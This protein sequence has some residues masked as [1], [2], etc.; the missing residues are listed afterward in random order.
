MCLSLLLLVSDVG[1]QFAFLYFFS[2]LLHDVCYGELCQQV[3]V[4]PPPLTPIVML[5]TFAAEHRCTCTTAPAAHPQLLIEIRQ[6]LQTRRP[7]LLLLI[8]GT[9]GPMNI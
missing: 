9:D 3:C 1:V 6:Q 5:P 4:E 8:D 2:K 7:L